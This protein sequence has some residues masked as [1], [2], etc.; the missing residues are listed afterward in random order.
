VGEINL[1][2][3]ASIGVTFFPQTQDIDADQ[4]L[5][6]ADQAKLAGKNRFDFFDTKQDSS[7][8][9]HHESGGRIHQALA[10]HEFVLYYQPKVNMR[11]GALLGVEALIHWQHSEQG[12]LPPAQVQLGELQQLRDVMLDHLGTLEHESRPGDLMI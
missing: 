9:G 12:L 6:Q 1:Q 2:V 4:L 7:I 3:S 8:R 10:G 11:S 5:R